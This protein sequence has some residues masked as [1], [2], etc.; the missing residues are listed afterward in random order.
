MTLVQLFDS[1]VCRRC[2]IPL[3]AALLLLVMGAGASAQTVLPNAGGFQP[4]DQARIVPPDAK[5]ELLWAE[6]AFTEGPALA[7]DNAILFSDIGDT[8]YHFDPASREVKVFRH[9]SGKANGQMYDVQ[10]N[11]V[12]C[13][14][15]NGGNRRISITPPGG[16]VRTLSDNWRGKRFNSPNDLAITPQGRVYFTDPR[17]QGDEPREIDFEGVFFIDSNGVA[18]LATRDVSKPNGIMLSLDGRQIY[19]ADNDSRPAGPR[20]LLVF[21]VAQNG[22]LNHKRTLFSFGASRGID[23]MTLDQQG[24]LYAT[25]GKGKESGVYV[26]GPKGEQ[27]AVIA[28]P[29]APTNCVF[30]GGPDANVLYITAPAPRNKTGDKSASAAVKY[31]LY[32][33]RLK[34]PGRRVS[35]P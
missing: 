3:G 32:R 11:L 2:L 13:E 10:G 29:G 7:P 18:K 34:L 12:V 17:Y 26:F 14:G 35:R 28:V 31:A 5:L 19:I 33:I 30:G 16:Q 22:V 1:A 24:N 6:G 15:A 25:A 8:I 20:Q 9:P 21:R 23:G 4:T 27:L